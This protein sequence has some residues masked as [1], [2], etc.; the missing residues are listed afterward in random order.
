MHH[1]YTA[2]YTNKEGTH[3]YNKDND[4]FVQVHKQKIPST[5]ARVSE[6]F[7]RLLCLF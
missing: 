5:L 4:C 3:V 1:D 6:G 7:H 2:Y